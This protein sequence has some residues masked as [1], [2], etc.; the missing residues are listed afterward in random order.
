MHS[1]AG[2]G[3]RTK[4]SSGSTRQAR[5]DAVSCSRLLIKASP[6]STS[7]GRPFRTQLGVLERSNFESSWQLLSPE[8]CTVR[9]SRWPV[10]VCRA[11]GDARAAYV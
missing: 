6:C 1:L 5:D 2:P 7:A 11:W 8:R 4:W 10:G 9:A 3:F